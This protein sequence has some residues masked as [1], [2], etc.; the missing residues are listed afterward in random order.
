LLFELEKQRRHALTTACRRLHQGRYPDA[1]MLTEGAE[2][3][4]RDEDTRR[5][6]A[7][8][9]LLQRDF[10]AAWKAYTADS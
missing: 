7:L 1:L 9:Y 10:A 4:R 5:L 2:A 8:L 3:L 6:R